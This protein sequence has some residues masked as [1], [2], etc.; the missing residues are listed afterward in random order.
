MLIDALKFIAKL[1]LFLPPM[2]HLIIWV[3]LHESKEERA[4]REKRHEENHISNG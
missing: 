1:A 2:V 3:L 4:E